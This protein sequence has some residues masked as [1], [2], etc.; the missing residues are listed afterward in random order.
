MRGYLGRVRE[1]QEAESEARFS[2][3][4]ISFGL[5]REGAPVSPWRELLFNPVYLSHSSE[6]LDYMDITTGVVIGPNSRRPIKLR[7]PI[8]IAGMGYGSIGVNQE[9]KRALAMGATLVGTAT[10]TGA[11]PFLE[12]ERSA[13]EKL[14]IQYA[15]GSWAKDL[16]VLREAEAV[17]IRLG[18]ERWGEGVGGLSAR[19]LARNPQ[20]W[21]TV[22][23]GGE[24]AVTPPRLLGLKDQVDLGR[25]IDSLR[26][27]TCG[28]PIGVKIGATQWLERELALITDAGPDYIAIEGLEAGGTS[29]G[30]GVKN[31]S[32]GLPTLYAVHRA[33]VFLREHGLR[34]KLNLL[35]GGGLR[36]SMEFLK[37]MA[38]GADAV[39]IG[40]AALTALFPGKE[41]GVFFK[42]PPG[43][44]LEKIRKSNRLQAPQAAQ[45]LATV[46]KGAL[47]EM[48]FTAF[49]LGKNRL[50]EITR[51]DL[52]TTDHQLASIL[53]ISWCGLEAD[54]QW[55]PVNRETYN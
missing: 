15:K 33:D 47:H 25:L 51:E 46:L 6:K 37:A 41:M 12:T 2:N 44:V 9:V 21:E 8:L 24:K 5:P 16:E 10:N 17:E 35:V 1:R 45:R 31:D 40:T 20:L 4:P 30:M 22:R 53:K 23:V 11:G 27:K 34:K 50:S 29:G 54:P 52:S 38:L 32:L 18:A 39:F 13:A 43:S 48:Q 7:I 42:R 55:W 36:S 26:R 14:I 19:R 3:S 49:S 28:I